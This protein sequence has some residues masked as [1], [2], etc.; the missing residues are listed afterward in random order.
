MLNRR[1]F[2]TRS[3][4]ALGAIVLGDEVLE[5]FA[6][7]THVR[8]SF[9]SAGIPGWATAR[10]LEEG[11][12]IKDWRYVTVTA[13]VDVSMAVASLEVSR[14]G[15]HFTKMATRPIPESGIVHFPSVEGVSGVFT[16]QFWNIPR[17]PG[18]NVRDTRTTR[19]Y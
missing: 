17:W 1:C 2:L 13:E 7:L 5:A 9:P 15:K 19:R 14:D 4:L 10:E 3:G 12:V 16:A 6:R 18:V 11:L 8:K